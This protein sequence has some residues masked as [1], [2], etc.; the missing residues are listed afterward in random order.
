MYFDNG[1]KIEFLPPLEQT[2]CIR[3]RKR[4]MPPEKTVKDINSTAH[5]SVSKVCDPIEDI[6]RSLAGAHT[7][8]ERDNCDE[9][10]VQL[11][12]AL[13]N[14]TIVSNYSHLSVLNDADILF[15]PY[16]S[17]AL[18][19]SLSR[20]IASKSWKMCVSHACLIMYLF[21]SFTYS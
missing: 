20:I 11:T 13:L 19:K 21:C 6:E 12:K 9:I 8:R 2:I 3:G 16:L 18:L 15:L 1:M 7:K 5:V 10:D 4:P 17:L 14:R